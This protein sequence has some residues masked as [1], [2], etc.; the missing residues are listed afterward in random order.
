M[1]RTRSSLL[2]SL[3][4][5]AAPLAL[6][7]AALGCNGAQQKTPPPYDS[8]VPCTAIAA[9]YTDCD[10]AAPVAPGTC[11]TSAS[12]S[13]PTVARIPAGNYPVGCQVQF[14]FEDVQA[15]GSCDPAVNECSCLPGDAGGG[16]AA[17]VPGYW[18]NCADAGFPPVQ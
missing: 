1:T 3:V 16:D 6:A 9:I 15:G 12:S 11:T 7:G 18:T 4:R 14:Y 10:A 8:G 2:L 5:V 17:S 13:D